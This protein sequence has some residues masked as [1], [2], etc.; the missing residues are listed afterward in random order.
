MRRCWLRT[1]ATALNMAIA[2]A[3]DAW[4]GLKEGLKIRSIAQTHR[5]E[6]GVEVEVGVADRLI[7]HGASLLS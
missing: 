6:F 5:N 3:P 1:L 2:P 4:R 7:Q